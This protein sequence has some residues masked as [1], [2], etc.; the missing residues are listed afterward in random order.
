MNDDPDATILPIGETTVSSPDGSPSISQTDWSASGRYTPQTALAQGGLGRVY[1]ALDRELNREVALKV[2]RDEYRDA[3]EHRQRFVVEGE[4]TGRLEHPGVVPIYGMGI[5]DRGGPYYAMRLIRG[6]SLAQRIRTA[7]DPQSGETTVP[8]TRLLRSFISVCYTI[9]YAHD[10][11]VLHRDIKPDNIMLGPYDETLVVDWGL[12]KIVNDEASGDAT[13]QRVPSGAGTPKS[14]N[15]NSFGDPTSATV[16]GTV[17]GTP[18]YMSPEQARGEVDRLDGRSDVYSLGAVLFE[19]VCG[20]PMRPSSTSSDPIDLARQGSR[21]SIEKAKPS[22]PKPLRAICDKA[23]AVSPSHRYPDAASLA[24]DVESYL[25][26]EPI[27]A[28]PDR[29]FDATTRWMRKHRGIVGT[30]AVGG[31]ALATIALTAAVLLAGKNRMIENKNVALEQQQRQT[32]SNLL[33]AQSAVDDYLTKI[34]GDQ[35]LKTA[36]LDKLRL[37]L[38]RGSQPYLDRFLSQSSNSVPLLKKQ[39]DVLSRLVDIAETSRQMLDADRYAKKN[40]SLLS[41]LQTL[42][43]EDPDVM[44]AVWANQSR[45]ARYHSQWGRFD[46]ALKRG[47]HVIRAMRLEIDRVRPSDTEFIDVWVQTH[48]ALSR[49]EYLRGNLNE[50]RRWANDARRGLD[51][52]GADGHW[53]D[54]IELRIAKV[55]ASGGDRT[56]A[57][58][59]LVRLSDQIARRSDATGDAIQRSL[60][61]IEVLLVLASMLQ[62]D[63]RV[64]AGIE[65]LRS[66][67]ADAERLQQTYPENQQVRLVR[68]K[69]AANLRNATNPF[70]ERLPSGD[71]H[72]D[73]NAT[74]DGSIAE[75]TDRELDEIRRQLQLDPNNLELRRNEIAV[76]NLK[77]TELYAQG[78]AD[79][80]V[81]ILRESIKSADDLVADYPDAWLAG[82]MQSGVHILLGSLLESRDT[83]VAIR[84][85]RT[86][87]LLA[88][89]WLPRDFELSSTDGERIDANVAGS[90]IATL[91]ATSPSADEYVQEAVDAYVSGLYRLSSLAETQAQRLSLIA[92]RDQLRSQLPER[93][94][95][96]EWVTIS[97]IQDREAEAI[98]RL[99]EDVDRSIELLHTAL[100]L[101]GRL[102]ETLAGQPDQAV[103]TINLI[104]WLLMIFAEV[105]PDSDRVE[106]LTRRAI[107]AADAVDPVYLDDQTITGVALRA[108]MMAIRATSNRD[109]DTAR[110]FIDTARRYFDRLFER[111]GDREHLIETASLL[112]LPMMSGPD[113]NVTVGGDDDAA[114]TRAALAYLDRY[115][116][117]GPPTPRSRRCR[118]GWSMALSRYLQP[119]DHQSAERV[120]ETALLHADEVWTKPLRGQ[121]AVLAAQTGDVHRVLSELEQLARSIGASKV[122]DS[123]DQDDAAARETPDDR[124]S[125]LQLAWSKAV[126]AAGIAAKSDPEMRDLLIQRGVPFYEQLAA[127]AS[128]ESIR[129][130]LESDERAG[131]I[132]S[133][134]KTN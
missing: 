16:V 13:H 120:I 111:T 109:A 8:I 81:A 5:D 18:A 78:N 80:A 66:A 122:D 129:Q 115:E 25:S 34:S 44:Q 86:G 48:L 28:R 134:R 57:R 38:A 125:A 128:A 15:T 43:P 26:D 108:S 118:A 132:I 22:T 59:R 77:A 49:N 10:R 46:E 63:E 1:T 83:D 14:T 11:G 119:R 32:R 85:T 36:G 41:R 31:I 70:G 68:L 76:A 84:E 121:R 52:I 133:A 102:D 98:A 110:P 50:A 99:N 35:R 90:P 91:D 6:D 12:G 21:R 67:Q 106:T 42:A 131:P 87:V 54:E 71:S 40:E 74:A 45:L 27:T 130:S 61:R 58:Q 94:R 37:E 93:I 9:Q 55:S 62:M 117:D 79:R 103:R 96:N 107:A 39:T 72:S 30:A 73:A 126:V 53:Y 101:N 89:K 23:T 7:H 114:A 97:E 75:N 105:D 92:A 33:L 2:I 64:T 127:D 123:A 113:G 124:R 88:K 56:S 95:D 20:Q 69:V 65:T 116:S 24:S 82:L 112:L 60:R 19:I 100:S 4:L 29:W 104:E 51:Q 3:A 17:V 47:G